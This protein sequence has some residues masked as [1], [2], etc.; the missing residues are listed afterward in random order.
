[1]VVQD[2]LLA[3]VLELWIATSIV[4]DPNMQWVISLNPTLAPQFEPA[5]LHQLH[6]VNEAAPPHG[7]KLIEDATNNENY[8]LISSQLRSAA[9]K[10][11]AHLSK[12]VMNDLEKRLLQRQQSGWFETFLV[13]VVL[14][15]CVER[16]S[17]LFR[18]W[19]GE[20]WYS[21]V[22][23]AIAPITD[24]RASS[25]LRRYAELVG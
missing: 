18:T 4:V 15:N 11:A 5:T 2:P 1:M 9:E 12:S 24:C 7:H 20:R 8:Q 10:R 21:K 6:A 19:E 14:L 3:R 17:W 22:S 23:F 13:A 16:M 25:V